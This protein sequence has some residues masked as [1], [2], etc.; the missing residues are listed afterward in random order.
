MR[1]TCILKDFTEQFYTGTESGSIVG[2]L[3]M[4]DADKWEKLKA[5]AGEKRIKIKIESGQFRD[6]VALNQLLRG[7]VSIAFRLEPRKGYKLATFD[8]T[9]TGA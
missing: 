4:S 9:K 5:M 1:V 3:N 6:A 2:L 8:I 7:P